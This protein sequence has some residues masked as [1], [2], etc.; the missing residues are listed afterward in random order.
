MV[1]FKNIYELNHDKA[2]EALITTF[3]SIV[4]NSSALMKVMTF[5]EITE[6]LPTHS[7]LVFE[8]FSQWKL[9]PTLLPSMFNAPR[10]WFVWGSGGWQGPLYQLE[11]KSFSH[12]HLM[13][14]CCINNP[15][16]RC[17][18]SVY[19]MEPIQINLKNMKK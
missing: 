2:I 16:L 7:V 14:C 18:C 11:A 4:I 6:K 19:L 10:L 17:A 8:N 12:W 15:E 3:I 13:V 5:S 9:T 1:S